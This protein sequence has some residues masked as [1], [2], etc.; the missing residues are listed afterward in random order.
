MENQKFD[1]AEISFDYT[2]KNNQKVGVYQYLDD[3]SYKLVS[4]GTQ[5]KLEHFSRYFLGQIIEDKES[6]QPAL[7]IALVIDNSGSMYSQE[8]CAGSAENDVD[9]KRVDM[10][11]SLVEK[12]AQTTRFSCYTF[13]RDITK[14]TGLTSD[15][16]ALYTSI[17][18]IKD[19]VPKFNGTA[20]NNTIYKALS[21]FED[22]KTRRHYIILLSD[23]FDKGGLFDWDESTD[24][25][26]ARAAEK[27]TVIICIGLGNE[28]DVKHLTELATGTGGF[29]R[30]ARSADDLT[31]LYEQIN[32]VLN[33]NYVDTDGDGKTDSILLAD[34]G[35]NIDTDTLPFNNIRVKDKYIP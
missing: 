11:K 15:K 18:S 26:I 24:S 27:N 20:S 28:I 1:S 25:V 21:D 23:G 22:D 12:A 13:T 19:T 31:D 8:Q 7:D 17:N 5:A 35:F 32:G 3:G 16:N 29:Y 9:F 30:Y 10:A 6:F 14:V 4:E 34:S 2:S 33:N